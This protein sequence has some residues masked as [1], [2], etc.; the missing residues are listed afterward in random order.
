M[1]SETKN[2]NNN[3]N[4]SDDGSIAVND[5]NASTLSSSNKIGYGLG[6]VFNDLCATVWFS[7]TLLFLKD[8]LKMPTEAGSF[9]ML[10]QFTDAFF[11]LIVGTLTD[12]YST[13]RNWHLIGSVIVCLSFPMIF[14]L[15][16]DIFPY[17][18]NIFYFSAIIPLFQCG[19]AIVQIS[20]L[21]I[22]PEYSITERDRTELN[23]VRFSM[24]ILSNITVFIV[25][26]AFLHIRDKTMEEEIGPRDFDKFRV[27]QH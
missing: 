12:L 4:N 2:D 18:G 5:E 25:A 21:S 7:Y 10:G 16:R 22:L 9:M 17:W 27:C 19:W 3:N 11:T 23:A 6:H 1:A 24:S 14:V 13:K 8:V 15:Q 26:Y 20:H